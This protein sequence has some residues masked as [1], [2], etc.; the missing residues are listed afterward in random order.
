MAL[1]NDPETLNNALKDKNTCK[2][3]MKA[4]NNVKMLQD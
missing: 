3:I 2:A 1:L 4:Y